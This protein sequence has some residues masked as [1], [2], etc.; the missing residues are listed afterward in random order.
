MER[1]RELYERALEVDPT[2]A[3]NLSNFG[4]FLSDVS[5]TNKYIQYF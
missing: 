2:H 1:A 3:N 5:Q 4:L